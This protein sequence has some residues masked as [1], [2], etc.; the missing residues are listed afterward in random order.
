MG[1]TGRQLFAAG[2]A[3]AG[4]AAGGDRPPAR[5]GAGLGH[6]DDRRAGR[7]ARVSAG[8][9]TDGFAHQLRPRWSRGAVVVAV[10]ALLL[11]ADARGR[12]SESVDPVAAPGA[13]GRQAAGWSRRLRR[14]RCGGESRSA[15]GAATAPTGH[16]R[17]APAGHRRRTPMT[18]RLTRRLAGRAASP[19]SSPSPACAGDDSLEDEASGDGSPAAATRAGRH[20]RPELHREPDPVAAMYPQLLENAGYTVTI[21]LVDDPRRLP[22][23]SCSKGNVDIVPDYLGGHDRLPQHRSE[24]GPDAKP[25]ATNDAD[26]HARGAR[27]AR[28][29]Q[30]ISILTPSEAT[31]ANAFFVTK[32]F[33]EENDVTTLSRPRGARQ[34]GHARRRPGL[35]GPRRLRGRADGRLRHRHHQG[36]CRSASPAPR[37]PRT[38]SRAARSQLGETG[39][40]DGT[41][42][43]LGP[44]AARGRP[45]AS[46]RRRTSCRRSTATSS[47]THPDVGRRPQRRCPRR[48]PPTTSPTMNGQV[49]LERQKPEDVAQQ[50][51]EDKGLL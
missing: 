49:D 4:D 37:L 29:A 32:E 9:I 26:E 42:E 43:D 18:H 21:K 47:P 44:G 10:V 12:R 17:H 27:A 19:C 8:S 45:G 7:R 33:A 11:E 40:T 28:D 1:M 5:A 24:N 15:A 48:S 36:R 39:T 51:L 20:R 2:R 22:A 25:V 46:S 30:G 3:A 41:L 50:F 35:R 16:A 31:D 34:A 38:P 23:P 6:R 13:A 14:E